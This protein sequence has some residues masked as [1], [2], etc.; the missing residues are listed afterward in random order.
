[1]TRPICNHSF[2]NIS[3]SH[4]EDMNQDRSLFDNESIEPKCLNVFT[5]YQ[6]VCRRKFFWISCVKSKG[7][8][9]SYGEF[10]QS[11]NTN[12]KVWFEIKKGLKSEIKTE[13]DKI[14]IAKRTMSWILRPSQ[15][16]PR[17]GGNP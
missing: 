11:W 1:M 6:D 10:K 14:H 5:N 17:N 12:T 3:A 9:A 7:T 2:N 4:A 16:N 8:F 13:L 15:R